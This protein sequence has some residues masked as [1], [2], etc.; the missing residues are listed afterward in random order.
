MDAVFGRGIGPVAQVALSGLAFGVAHGI[1]GLMGRGTRAA[2]GATVATGVLGTALALVYLVAGRSL[3]PCIVAHF[4][5]NLLIEPG[6]V[7]AALSG[8]MNGSATFRVDRR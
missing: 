6:L 7:L 8:E 3:A 2:F 5:I 4:V 1:W